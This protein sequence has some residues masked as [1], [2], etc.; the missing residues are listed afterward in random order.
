M[1]SKVKS[2][3]AGSVIA[4]LSLC[5]F[6]V[7]GFIMKEGNLKDVLF[8]IFSG[9]F[10]SAFVT[11]LIY[12]TEYRVIKKEVMEEYWNAIFKVNQKIIQIPFLVFDEPDELV[13]AYFAEMSHNS[14][15]QNILKQL[16]KDY[17]T[18]TGD[19][20]LKILREAEDKMVEYMRP[21]YNRLNVEQQ[22]IDEIIKGTL[23]EKMNA[24]EEKINKIM[25]QYIKI[26]DISYGMCENAYGKMYFFR[27]QKIRNRVYE[28]IHK[29]L[30]DILDK[31][32]TRAN[33][34]FKLHFEKVGYNLPVMID[35]INELQR[36]IFEVE[37]IV[38]DEKKGYRL[39]K[40]AR[41]QFYFKMDKQIE[42]FRTE[43]YH[44]KPEYQKEFYSFSRLW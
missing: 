36:E 13:K 43:I 42:D 1:E 40:N 3:K 21:R 17:V 38:V 41:N 14:M 25:E 28:K 27:S 24:Y 31:I 2:I 32:K 7:I 39:V 6:C 11:I 22:E 30:R 23:K 20:T 8:T 5:C 35:F 37:Y 29:P 18:S 44:C 16:R 33:N 12:I 10:T 34:N 15:A 26:A 9:I 19:D 4:I